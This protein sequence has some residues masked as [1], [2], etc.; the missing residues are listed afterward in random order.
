MGRGRTLLS[1]LSIWA[2]EGNVHALPGG[3]VESKD[4]PVESKNY[5]MRGAHHVALHVVLHEALESFG[6]PLNKIIGKREDEL[7]HEIKNL[8][9]ENSR[10]REFFD[11]TAIPLGGPEKSLLEVHKSPALLSGLTTKN[12][13]H[14]LPDSIEG[15]KNGAQHVALHMV[16]N[17]AL[18]SFECQLNKVIGKREE[19]LLNEIR[20]LQNENSRLRQSLDP[21]ARNNFALQVQNKSLLFNG[22]DLNSVL[23]SANK[24]LDFLTESALNPTS[25]MPFLFD[26]NEEKLPPPQS[27]FPP[28]QSNLVSPIGKL[29]FRADSTIVEGD[30][31]KHNLPCYTPRIYGTDNTIVPEDDDVQRNLPFHTTRIT[32]IH[33]YCQ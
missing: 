11:Q 18:G 17:E 2:T 7:L 24:T 31:G 22:L 14:A 28:P 19:E 25:L 33:K 4:Y 27:D 8:Q 23:T 12:G 21:T 1:D 9:D 13:V 6:C 32:G 20:R 15:N 26:Q 5:P 16:L 30:E 10:L 29:Q 3:A